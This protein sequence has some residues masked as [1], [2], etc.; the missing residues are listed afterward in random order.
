[1]SDADEQRL[2]AVLRREGRSLLRYAREAELYAGP[3]DRKLLAAVHRAADE[4]AAGLQG[5]EGVLT[6][7]RVLP[8]PAGPYPVGYT[9]LNFTA[10]RALLPRLAADLGRAV[11]DLDTD[12]AALTDPAASAAVRATAD[13]ARRNLVDLQ[14]AGG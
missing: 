11:A 12:A 3:A 10:V 1:M 4:L 5:V 13:A 14:P 9:D 8:A 7:A 2:Q 6:A